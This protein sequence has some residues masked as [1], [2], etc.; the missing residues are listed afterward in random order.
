MFTESAEFYDALYSFRDYAAETARIAEVVRWLHPEARTVLDVACGTGEHAA[1]LASQHGFAVDGLDLD[2]GMVQIARAKN[3]A[4]RFVEADM[5]EFSLDG[6][7]D[8]ILCLFS[9]IAYLVTLDRITRALSGFRRHLTA[10][11]IVIVEPWFPPGEL[12]TNRVWRLTGS[13]EGVSVTR[14][15]RNEID[16]RISRLRFEYEIE[17]AQ[18]IRRASEV[19]ELGLFTQEEMRMAFSAAGLVTTYDPVG[20]SGRGLWMA[21]DRVSA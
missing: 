16:G 9:S 6:R 20:L 13:H 7:Y 8:V 2:R 15:S 5:I 11:G 14:V 1:R 17:S 3:R 10:K 21:R 18:G 12:D 4:G 19:H